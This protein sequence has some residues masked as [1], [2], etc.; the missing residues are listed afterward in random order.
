METIIQK[1]IEG[2][3]G[4]IVGKKFK[5]F[6]ND[7]IWIYDYPE[8]PEMQ[9][10]HWFDGHTSDFLIDPLFWQALEVGGKLRVPKKVRINS[11]PASGL[12]IE[13]V[14]VTKSPAW[15]YYWHRFIDA[16]AEGKT[17]D[18]FFTNL[19]TQK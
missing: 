13:K 4:R 1:A 11:G 15:V 8:E 7:N 18:Q 10:G 3:Y 2:G 16:L 6:S 12:R 17:P 14:R 9:D 19:I 5:V